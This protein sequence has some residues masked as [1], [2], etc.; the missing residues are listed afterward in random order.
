VAYLPSMRLDGQVALVTGASQGLGRHLALALAEAGAD[1]A[2][3]ARNAV[4]LE[5]VAAEV[6]RLGRAALAVRADLARVAEGPR[7]VADVVERFGRLDVLVN[8]AGTN[9]PAPALEV[10][11]E[12]WDRVVDLNLKGAFF[13]AQAAGRRM[14]EQ[15]HGG[16]IVNIASQMAEVGWHDRS[17]YCA[18]KGGL[19]QITKVLALEWAPHGV[20]VNAVGPTFVDTPMTRPMFEDPDFSAA[21]LRN[22]P[23]GRLGRMEEVAAAVVFLASPGADLVTGHHLL[24]DG[25]WTIQ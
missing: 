11:E 20:R 24:A 4:A 17:V 16:R 22:I 8:N 2:L 12:Q 6:K 18:T 10:T 19:T 13:M 21:V 14:I 7:V 15:G 5:E 9:V 23:I 1:V 25:G 3:A